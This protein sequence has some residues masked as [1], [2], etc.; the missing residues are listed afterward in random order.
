[1]F[2]IPVRKLRRRPIVLSQE[3]R[4][5]SKRDTVNLQDQ[6]WHANRVFAICQG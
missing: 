4:N 2:V 5:C 3:A 1:M 6:L